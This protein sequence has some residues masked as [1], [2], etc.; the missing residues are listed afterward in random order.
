M[1]SAQRLLQALFLSLVV[2]LT[3][4]AT[5]QQAAPKSLEYP[6]QFERLQSSDIEIQQVRFLANPAT[7]SR[8]EVVCEVSYKNRGSAS[9]VLL[10][11]ET[12][13]STP[14]QPVAG[15]VLLSHASQAFEVARS[16][17][18]L[19]NNRDGPIAGRGAGYK[20]WLGHAF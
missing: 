18:F 16:A 9:P 14:E 12:W 19:T 15:V 10:L 11:F 4:C 5:W 2:G 6:A 1:S 13:S 3:G 17:P 20:V 7:S 8:Y